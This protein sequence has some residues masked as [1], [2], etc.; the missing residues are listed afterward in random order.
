MKYVFSAALLFAS[1]LSAPAV[2]QE[3]DAER[4]NAL[5]RRLCSG[6]H[7]V[8]QPRNGVGPS[9]QGVIGR[10][11]GSVEGFNYSPALRE[12]GITW[13]PETLDA[14][15]ADPRGMV[16]GTRMVQRVPDEQQ[17]LDLIEFL[18]AQ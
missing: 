17:R 5:F 6:C 7:Q 2:A 11:A 9:L 18:A 10:L 1:V 13:T 14:Y 4:G 15:L 16:R 3:G 12:S 8:A